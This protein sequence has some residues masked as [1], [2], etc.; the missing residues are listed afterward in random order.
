MVPAQAKTEGR[1]SAREVR[2]GRGLV[3][4]RDDLPGFRAS[5]FDPDYWHAQGRA[6]PTAAGR[7]PARPIRTIMWQDLLFAIALALVIV[8]LLP[9]ANPD[10]MR[11]T[12]M[13]L[14]QLDDQ[15]L[16]FAGLTLMVVGCLMLYVVR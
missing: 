4:H 9:F 12:M 6:R 15:T 5:F 2:T 1:I 3:L 10:A 14:L 11:R 7:D 13:R 8:G 16:R